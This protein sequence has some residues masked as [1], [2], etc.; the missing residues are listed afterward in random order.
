M[1]IAVAANIIFTLA[2]S[3]RRLL[4]DL[5][6]AGHE[7]YLLAP[8]GPDRTDLAELP[9]TITYV[10]LRNL[11]RKGF[12]PVRDLALLRELRAAYRRYGIGWAFLFNIKPVIYGSLAARGSDV[13]VVSTITGTGNVLLRSRPWPAVLLRLYRIAL[14]NNRRVFVQNQDDHRLFIDKRLATR[15]QL[16]VVGGAG[17]DLEEFPELPL[18]R[19]DHFVFVGRLLADKG[20][21]ELLTAARLIGR[22]YPDVRFTLVGAPDEHNALSLRPEE[23]AAYAGIPGVTFTGWRGDVRPYLAAAS[24]VMLPSYHEGLPRVLIEGAATGRPLIATDVPGCREVVEAGTNGWLVPARSG[25]QLAAAM[26]SF[27]QLPQ[28]ERQALGQASRRLAE[29]RFDQRAVNRTYLDVI[30]DDRS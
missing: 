23:V 22:D 5:V 25:T 21:G 14:G 15:R 9:P 13:A 8:D 10:P 1:K 4:L 20:V 16:A 26:R 11:D 6:A 29:R 18:P 17:V 30:N 7:V 19:E 28:A 2:R 3:R 12:N 24:C 27:L